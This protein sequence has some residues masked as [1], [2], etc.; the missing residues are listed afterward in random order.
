LV[1]P[2]AADVR[3]VIVEGPSGLLSIAPPWNMPRYEPSKRRLTWPNG[4]VAFT[5]SAEE[6]ERLRGPQHDA[7][8]CDELG[9]WE[10]PDAWSNLMLGLRIGTNPSVMVTT[11]P[12]NTKL[13]KGILASPSTRLTRG[14]TYENAANLAPEFIAEIR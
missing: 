13:L 10:R 8:Y 4:S 14:A 11:T 2:T 7:A 5:Y 9:S 1:A 6:P 3:D 12:R